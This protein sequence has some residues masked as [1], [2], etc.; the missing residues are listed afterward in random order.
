MNVDIVLINPYFQE[1]LYPTYIGPPLGLLYLASCLEKKGYGVRIIDALPLLKTNKSLVK[2]LKKINPEI[3]G[4]TNSSLQSRSA[5]SLARQIK[6]SSDTKIIVGGSHVTSRPEFCRYDCFD[7]G[8]S[9]EGEISLPDLVDK[10]RQNKKSKKMIIGKKVENLDSIPFPAWHLIKMDDYHK[11]RKRSF[12]VIGSRGCPYRCIFCSVRGPVRF[13]SPINVLKELKILIEKYRVESIGFVDNTFTLNKKWVDSLCESIIKE[14]LDF[15]WACITRC[16]HLNRNIVKK[17]SRAGC[18]QIGLGIET[19]PSLRTYLKKDLEE[20]SVKSAISACKKEGIRSIGTFI[21][22]LPGETFES[23]QKT[24]KY[25]LKL[26][27]DDVGYH[28]LILLPGT[29]IFNTAIRDG[30][31]DKDLWKN[32]EMGIGEV[33]FFIPDSLNINIISKLRKNGYKEFYFKLNYFVR[34]LGEIKSLKNIRDV[35]LFTESF[36]KFI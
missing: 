14:K 5:L 33:P 22:G 20:R 19:R 23:I 16:D 8:I 36:K 25:S 15:R 4:I 6:E 13:R 12:N 29:E 1:P 3:I 34:K 17:M 18:D 32:Y 31:A 26:G 10:I 2:E 7:Y 11:D 35:K 21:L 30:I 28:L 27:L 24:I 9:G